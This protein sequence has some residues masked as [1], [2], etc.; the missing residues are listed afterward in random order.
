MRKLNFKYF[1]AFAALGFFAS[2][3][4]EN[5]TTDAR[6]VKPVVTAALTSYTVAEGASA[7]VNLT[8]NTPYFR[9]LDY[10]LELVGG[11][12]SFRDFTLSLI[13]I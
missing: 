5:E 1:V 7:T 4:P 10:K 8:V 9:S 13:H 6:V 2:C 12:G 11:T 3:E